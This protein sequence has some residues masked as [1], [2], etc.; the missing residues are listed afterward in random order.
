MDELGHI[1]L[2]QRLIPEAMAI[3]PHSTDKLYQMVDEAVNHE[4][5]WTNHIC[6]NEVL[7]ITEDS[8]RQY[9]QYLGNLRLKTI[10]LNPIYTGED[11]QKS[12]YSHLEKMG[13]TGKDGSTKANFF[14]A[15]VTGYNTAT[16]IA[17]WDE[18]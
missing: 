7:G 12:P 18:I 11:C 1:R 8:S 10:G 9:S 3:F 16:A 17:G 15:T 2:F 5:N 4:I 13:D 6:D 14:E